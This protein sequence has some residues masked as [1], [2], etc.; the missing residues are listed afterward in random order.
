[1]AM[2]SAFR[3]LPNRIQF[4]IVVM[5][6]F[7]FMWMWITPIFEYVRDVSGWPPWLQFIIGM[8]GVFIVIK[9]WRLHPW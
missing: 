4:I 9:K 1:M 2:R 3:G 8:I 7:V 5:V 6:L